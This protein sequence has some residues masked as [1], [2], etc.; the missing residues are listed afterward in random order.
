MAKAADKNE[1]I[2]SAPIQGENQRLMNTIA[3]ILDDTFNG[4][5]KGEDRKVGFVLMVFN[6][7]DV[8]PGAR[9]NYISNTRREDIII[10]LKEQIQYFEGQAEVIGHG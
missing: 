7:K 9:C 5:A 10:M 4:P 6:F 2:G 1:Q 3:G 8:G